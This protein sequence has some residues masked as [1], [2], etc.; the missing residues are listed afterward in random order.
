MLLAK[1][2]K[3]QN[4]ENF[5]AMPYKFA[6]LTDPM[7]IAAAISARSTSAPSSSPPATSW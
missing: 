2:N 6:I 1:K 3:P 5:A 7:A 4:V